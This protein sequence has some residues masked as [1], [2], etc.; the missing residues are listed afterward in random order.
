LQITH[1]T[2]KTAVKTQNCYYMSKQNIIK[3]NGMLC[4]LFT[5]LYKETLYLH[6]KHCL[7]CS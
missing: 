1:K 4:I 6:Y 2:L 5:K 3:T 7:F